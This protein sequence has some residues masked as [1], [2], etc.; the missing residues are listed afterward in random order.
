MHTFLDVYQR[1]VYLSFTKAPFSDSPRHVWVIC[2]FQ[3]QWLLTNHKKRGLEFPGGKI[4]P[5]ERAEDAAKREVLEETGAVVSNL[6][7]LGQ[8]TVPDLDICKNVYMAT[9]YELNQ[10]DHYYETNGPVLVDEL[11]SDIGEHEEYSFIMKDDVLKNCLQYIH[12]RQ[13]EWV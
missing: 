4:E 1:T 13:F 3:D 9:I 6:Y 7:Y 11:P 5:G 8:Y 12:D 2:R 10:S